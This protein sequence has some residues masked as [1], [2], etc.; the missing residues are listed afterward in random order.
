[1]E[2]EPMNMSRLALTALLV[3][4]LSSFGTLGC[5]GDSGDAASA[6]AAA[7]EAAAAPAAAPAADDGLTQ[8]PLIDGL[9]MKVP[10]NAKPNLGAAGFHTE[11]DTFGVMIRAKEPATT[12]EQ[13]KADAEE[14]LFNGWLSSEATDDGWVLTWES[15]T[16]DMEGNTSP[17]FAFEVVRTLDGTQYGCSGSLKD[18][19]GLDAVVQACKTLKRG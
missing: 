6:D 13:A 12:M 2:E 7:P 4:T 10:E 17:A 9:R 5:G 18:K 14:F 3:G 16:M 1:L 8:V 19:A 11:D 15:A